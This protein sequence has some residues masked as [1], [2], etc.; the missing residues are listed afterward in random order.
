MKKGLVR[1][2]SL[3]FSVILLFPAGGVFPVNGETDLLVYEFSG[4]HREEPGYGEG[5]ITLT[6]GE[7]APKSGY[8][9]FCF[10]DEEGALSGYEA[11]ALE[12]VSAKITVKMP[13]G[14]LIPSQATKVAVFHSSGKKVKD[15]ALSAAFAVWDIPEEKRLEPGEVQGSFA[16]VSDVHMN[17]DDNGFGA[18]A[19]WTAALKFFGEKKME[20]VV[21]SGDI[22]ENG[23]AL[24]YKRYNDAIAASGYPKEQ[25]YEARGNHDSQ[26]NRLFLINT[27]GEDECRPYAD[28]PYF[29]LLKE[30][31]PGQKDN[32]FIFM[33]QE[34]SSVAATPDEDNFSDAQLDWLE[35]LL[36]TY[37]G[38]DTNIFLVEHSLI[39]N[40]GPGD[41]YD[42][43]YVQP[44]LFTDKY[45][46]NLRF[47][48]LLTEYKEVIFMSG[49]THLSLY[50]WQN[51]SDENGTACRMIH[52]SST[53]Q[54]RCYVGNS[55]SYNS[56]GKTTETY[57]S[58]GYLVYIY[59]DYI[60]YIGYNLST[61][62]I[63]PKA[64]F[65]I[66]SYSELRE[67]ARSV[68]VTAQPYKTE[69]K[70]G[71]FFDPSG[72]EV[73]AELADGSS[74][75]VDGWTV[76]QTCSL[77]EGQTE[78]EILYG[79][80]K[81]AKVRILVKS[82][83]EEQD[84]E[85]TGSH[86][87]PYLISTPEDFKKL[88]DLFNA[89]V[90]SSEIYGEGRFYRQTADIDMTGVEGYAGTPAN[91]NSKRYF[92]GN[93]DGDGYTLTV[94]LK[95][96]DQTSIF[97]YVYGVFTNLVLKGRISSP[98]SAQPF[99][100][101]QTG[102]VIANSV[103]ALETE[104][105]LAHGLCYSNYGTIFNVYVGGTAGKVFC[106]TD[107]GS[108]YL[109]AFYEVKDQNG[110]ALTASNGTKKAFSQAL[111]LLADQTSPTVEKGLQ[112]MRE[113]NGGFSVHDLCPVKGEAFEHLGAKEVE[114]GAPDPSLPPEKTFRLLPC[115]EGFVLRQK[116]GKA[117]TLLMLKLEDG[118]DES[119]E[120]MLF[121]E[122]G[123]TYILTIDGITKEV[124]PTEALGRLAL[125]FRTGDF[126]RPET[127]GK[128]YS[129]SLVVKK[130]DTVLFE[131]E[132]KVFRKGE[133][134]EDRLPG[135]QKAENVQL[136]F[137]TGELNFGLTGKVREGDRACVTLRAGGKETTLTVPFTEKAGGRY[138]LSLKAALEELPAD[139][140]CTVSLT[141]QQGDSETA[142]VASFSVW[143]TPKN[144]PVVPTPTPEPTPS[145]TE[146][147]K[148]SIP[149]EASSASGAESDSLEEGSSAAL[150]FVWIG[151][152]VI[153]GILLV[154][155]IVLWSKKKEMSQK[156]T[157]R[158][159][160]P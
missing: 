153:C 106:S 92:G 146:T 108:V 159:K 150:V 34:L 62:E 38:T 60:T 119:L 129:L 139:A 120:R 107:K 48:Q 105:A 100:T 8:Y 66:S 21:I 156:D 5:T 40:F 160:K 76:R 46:N 59:E 44:I 51:Y 130:G 69:Y 17:Y 18:S 11:I 81:P 78:V 116:N 93:Y 138:A 2:F 124:V 33:A 42:G 102:S 6:P 149:S 121:K 96:N 52:N 125:V 135:E 83:A 118:Q 50:D 31:K 65:L 145:F 47:K 98:G 37:S 30:G 142:T 3:I 80:V 64:S 111:S 157:E 9:A 10:A 88:T 127:E 114:G 71:E 94:D 85:G 45:Q 154:M 148:T 90:S 14:T 117:E 72:M 19:K 95:G 104:S 75:K 77:K 49:H 32:L 27:M 29:Y 26:G 137:Q 12:K 91:G 155:G 24:N 115:Q 15:T 36:C 41:K 35:D 158:K 43:T 99:R 28:S 152:G 122:E 136:D 97:P 73:T 79:T 70:P 67:E 39:H 56:N 74:R 82:S 101:L 140:R 103:I 68:E 131:G 61:K 143:R 57:G 128:K 144:S 23:E 25:I 63:I 132:T 54:P 133:L 16:S 141:I 87:D 89:S 113:N 58:E 109:N 151:I 53:A 112:A 20:M 147:D 86:E 13:A 7:G 123:L 126:F 22:T 1:I 55:I 134:K 110:N 84:F 4:I